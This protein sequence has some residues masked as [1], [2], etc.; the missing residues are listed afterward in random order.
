MST[1]HTPTGQLWLALDRVHA[2][3]ARRVQA[4]M[5]EYG[6]TVPQYRVLR[7]LTDEG[8][9]SPNV[10]A[11]ALGVTPGNLTGVLDRLEAAGLLAR[12]RGN[13]DRRSLRAHITESGRALMARCVPEVRGHV[14]AL[15]APLSEAELDQA[16]RLLNRL[17]EHLGELP[18]RQPQLTE[19]SA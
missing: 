18:T 13:E 6:L 15:F 1:P 16:H 12:V 19:V 2:V 11:A 5:A 9:L 14:A 7:L 10:L 4:V 3:M 17:E 8:A